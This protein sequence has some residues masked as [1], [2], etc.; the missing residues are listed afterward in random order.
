M[1]RLE[2]TGGSVVGQDHLSRG[3]VLIG[4]PNQDSMCDMHSLDTNGKRTDVFVVCDGCGSAKFSEVGA[5][6]GA[7]IV[8]QSVMDILLERK[9]VIDEGIVETYL[10]VIRRIV[11]NRIDS[12][13]KA[14]SKWDVPPSYMMN[15]SDFFMFT[16][17]GAFFVDDMV[18]TFSIGD[19]YFVING[20]V[21]QRESGEDN[22]PPYIAYDLMPDSVFQN[23]EDLR[24]RNVTKYEC[25]RLEDIDSIIIASDGLR[26]ILSKEGHSYPGREDKIIP[27]VID[28]CGDDYFKNPAK[29]QREL[30]L[31]NTEK[32]KIMENGDISRFSGVLSDDTTLYVIRRKEHEN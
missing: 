14:M 27:S 20:Q 22:A 15:L 21:I 5:R 3:G 19:G 29:V 2:Y 16:I 23:P 8:C 30:N 1:K 25:H 13:V 12:Q 26:D 24:C 9:A 17:M 28:L 18:V 11:C 10:S 4:K 32:I 31:M 7:R 6:I